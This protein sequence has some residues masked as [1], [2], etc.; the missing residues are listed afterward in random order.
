MQLVDVS[1]VERKTLFAQ[2]MKDVALINLTLYL[3][4]Y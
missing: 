3:C 4:A 1:V 2:E